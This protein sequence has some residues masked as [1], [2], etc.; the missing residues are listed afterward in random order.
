MGRDI[1][2]PSEFSVCMATDAFR[3]CM[4]IDPKNFSADEVIRW[5]KLLQGKA[6]Q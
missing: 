3:I 1:S 6:G 4:G 5:I 2:N